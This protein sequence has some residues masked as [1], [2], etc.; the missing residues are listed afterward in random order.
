MYDT[1]I[2]GAHHQRSLGNG[3]NSSGGLYSPKKYG[4]SN[5]DV[6]APL[7]GGD[8][9]SQQSTSSAHHKKGAYTRYDEGLDI[10][11]KLKDAPANVEY[12]LCHTCHCVRPLRSKHDKMIN[13]C[14]HKFDH[15]W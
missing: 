15:F 9:L 2:S 7:T 1:D 6:T 13:R 3:N 10:I 11:A 5:S 4:D 14:V 12:K 8:H